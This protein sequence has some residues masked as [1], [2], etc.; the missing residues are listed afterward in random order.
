[1]AGLARLD[2]HAA[3]NTGASGCTFTHTIDEP[4][5]D[6][7]AYV[8]IDVSSTTNVEPS[9]T[10]TYGGQTCTLK[11]SWIIGAGSTW[12]IGKVFFLGNPPGGSQT[13]S[14]STSGGNVTRVAAN[15][16][17]YRNVLW[18]VPTGT[19]VTGD[20]IN[21][22]T[23]TVTNSE[24]GGRVLAAFFTNA[25]PSNPTQDQ[26]FSIGGAVTEYGDYLSAQDAAG[27]AS[28]SCGLSNSFA[29]DGMIGVP[30]APW[31]G[32]SLERFATGDISTSRSPSV[33]FTNYDPQ[34][35]DVVVLF[36][37]STGTGVALTI[38]SGWVNPLGGT[39]D[40]ESDAHEL[41][42]VYHLVTVAEAAA[43]TVTYTATNLFDANQTGNVIGVV[44]R[45]VSPSAV[46]DAYNTVYD[47][48]N[49]TPHL[50]NSLAG[51]NLSDNSYVLGCVVSDGTNTYGDAPSG[52]T[53]VA[54][55]NTN[56]GKVLLRRNS[57]TVAGVTVASASITPTTADEYCGI[58][59]AF[60]A[61][62]L[63]GS[64]SGAYTWVASPTGAVPPGPNVG[65]GSAGY[66][67][68]TIKR[69]PYTFPWMLGETKV[70]GEAPTYV[71]NGAATGGYGWV[72]AAVGESPGLPTGDTTGTYSFAAAAAGDAPS[73]GIGNSGGD[74]GW[75]TNAQ[76]WLTVRYFFP[77]PAVVA[78]PGPVISSRQLVSIHTFDG[79]QLYQFLPESQIQV[80]WNRT[81][82]DVSRCELQVPW[83]PEDER[84]PDITPWLHWISVWDETPNLLWTG[85]I[86]KITAGHTEITISARDV[87]S[88]MART[89]VSLTK[90]WDG[91]DLT[92]IAAELWRAM[93][94]NHSL[95]VH[96]IIRSDPDADPFD[97][98][99]EADAAMLDAKMNELVGLGLQW[100]VT[101]GVPIL[102][103]VSME[104]VTALGEN[105][106]VGG[107]IEVT[108][109]GAQTF[110][111]VVLRAADS[112]TRTRVPMAGLNLQTLVHIDSMFGVSNASR[113]VA[114]YA[115]YYGGIRTVLSMPS[116]VTLQP[117]AP[118]GIDQL[119]PSARFIVEAYGL[120]TLV[121]LTD[122]EV[123]GDATGSEVKVTLE[124]VVKLPELA[125]IAVLNQGG[126]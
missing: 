68:S 24:T 107:N 31:S 21:P 28:V 51:A 5:F 49:A 50:L 104:P 94:E 99:V 90:R 63:T 41:C 7:I 13:V 36:P 87:S 56:Q 123:S 9:Y 78:P 95:P 4:S 38:P 82:Q 27:G 59:L 8:L 61:G 32:V 116:G 80:N 115:R 57:R 74:W 11:G 85:P 72:A 114:Q 25:A 73:L 126:T 1:M 47:T 2:S 83:T 54:A 105:D 84:L 110:N 79:V 93:V 16:V 96:P 29:Y 64:A 48:A 19:Y 65:T 3:G 77:P 34:P 81:L 71:E 52:W 98:A 18:P 15:C 103:P 122:V 118:V 46:I 102:G 55:Y 44:V 124:S 17:V 14:V 22:D 60:T 119:I 35:N 23:I 97:F 26:L 58:T 53:K 89:R 113:A 10:V 62:P 117:F 40:I 66:G 111:D 109:D 76:G 20:G 33:T 67:W 101:A 12:M 112:V 43:D 39:T 125:E 42:C 92:A 106:F 69:L 30:I 91:A 75:H 121:K 100:T 37:S 6:T 120:T 108:R 88:F 86:Q 70:T 45:G